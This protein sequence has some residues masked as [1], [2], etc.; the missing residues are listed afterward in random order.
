MG[1][2]HLR[3]R[4]KGLPRLQEP[5]LR[6]QGVLLL[7]HRRLKPAGVPS[8]SGGRFSLVKAMAVRGWMPLYS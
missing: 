5:M 8:H 4:M 1:L 7:M 6:W 3:G 2:A